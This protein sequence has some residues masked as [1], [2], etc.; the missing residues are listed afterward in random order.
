MNNGAFGENFPYTNFHDLNMDWIIKIAKDFLDQYTNI[1]NIITNGLTNLQ[2][3][4]NNGLTELQN[5][6]EIIE[7]LLDAWYT[8]H[9]EDI[10]SQLA[11]A[12]ADLAES[13]QNAETE[14]DTTLNT[15][16]NEFVSFVEDAT[17]SVLA[18][19]PADYSALS[20]AV[21][22]LT[23]RTENYL[24]TNK[25]TPFG[26][27][28]IF[29]PLGHG[30]FSANG[31]STTAS[32]SWI[33]DD[34]ELPAGTYTAGFYLNSGNS[35][36]NIQI[37]KFVNG[38]LDTLI[39]Q[40]NN[41]GTFT[42]TETTTIRARFRVSG[43]D[44][45][46][47]NFILYPMILKSETWPIGFI[48]FITAY[49]SI[50]RAYAYYCYEK[51]INY[52]TNVSNDLDDYHTS[53]FY[54]LDSSITYDNSPVE[55][56][57]KTLIVFPTAESSYTL[58]MLILPGTGIIYTRRFSGAT[59]SWSDWASFSDT[60]V[61]QMIE[62]TITD[63]NDISENGWF[64]CPYSENYDNDP[65]GTNND[66][67]IIQ[68]TTG[69]NYRVQ[70]LI[71]ATRGLIYTRLRKGATPTWSA[72]VNITSSN[73]STLSE[74]FTAHSNNAQGNNVGLNLSVLSYNVANY[75][76]DS[77]TFI[78]DEHIFEFIKTL[79]D[80]NADILTIQ[81]DREYID[82]ENTKNTTEYL[83]YPSYPNRIGTGANTIRSKF[84]TSNSGTLTFS[85]GRILR[86]TVYSNGSYNLLICSTHMVWSY[87]NTDPDS[88]DSISARNIQYSELFNWVNGNIALADY[89]S[90]ILTYAPTHTHCIIGVDANSAYD[91]DKTN[92]TSAAT[93]AGFI[94]GNGG[95]IGWFK[96]EIPL[97][98]SIDNIIVSNNI[99]INSIEA[100]SN[101]YNRLYSDHIPILAKLTLI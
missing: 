39:L 13:L 64:I 43:A 63:F 26:T 95:R 96:T 59:P 93:N 78:D 35:P 52:K 29:T 77:N 27:D 75:N 25:D 88:A 46:A 94:M 24:E 20:T 1:Q 85:N 53:G 91:I 3:E 48:S 31:T 19:I 76:N 56:G 69:L 14:L 44:V 67:I 51:G 89:N 79:Y 99:I 9:S 17:E 65:I 15:N 74:S 98:V 32:F 66:R 84:P 40:T 5:K 73:D 100:F 90:G 101:L 68:Y 22:A 18:S 81:E 92:L 54:N 71:S 72:W 41:H 60:S 4:T 28:I 62:E 86:Y 47:D 55:A 34:I 42:I 36:I 2:N 7:G 21:N 16:K 50:A 23:D 30:V 10:A 61:F 70:I 97:N 8:E 45:S 83:Y 6:Y 33:T 57:A 87:N 12:L 80:C 82:E 38:T 11:D 58:Q 37:Y 49:D